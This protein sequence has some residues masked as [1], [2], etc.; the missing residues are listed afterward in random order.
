VPLPRPEKSTALT[1]LFI[2]ST[3]PLAGQTLIAWHMLDRLRARGAKTGFFKPL[4]VRDPG[5][6]YD[7]DATLFREVA[8]LSESAGEICPNLLTG[9]QD[10][11]AAMPGPAFLESVERAYRAREAGRDAMVVMGASDVFVSPDVTGLPDGKL[12]ERLDARVL[13]VDRFVSESHTV[14]STLAV[15]SFFGRSLRAI[16]VNQVPA[17]AIEPLRAKLAPVTRVIGEGA[18]ALVPQDRVIGADLVSDYVRLL[19]GEVLA[20]SE[21]TG[22]AV[23]A[24]TIGNDR[25]A[26]ALAILKR[27]QSKVVLL[28]GELSELADPAFEPRPVALIVT[29]GRMPPRVVVDLCAEHDLPLVSIEGDSFAMR[30]RLEKSRFP[31]RPEHAYKVWRLAEHLEGQLDWDRLLA[32]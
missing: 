28:G 10:E 5:S 4:G 27:V 9:K 21:R 1:P 23:C 11:T 17:G 25:F 22:G 8:E 16:V 20:A 7:P 15:A 12:I 2:S 13:L 26:K 3:G 6:G 19:G 32:G 29:S 31:V 18:L 24:T 30:D 14:Y